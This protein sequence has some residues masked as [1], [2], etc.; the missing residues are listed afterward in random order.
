[1]PSK[2]SCVEPIDVSRYALPFVCSRSRSL[3]SS[4]LNCIESPS[5]SNP[6]S[7]PARVRPTRWNVP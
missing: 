6:L 4:G 7:F 5:G 3:A 2:R 1:M